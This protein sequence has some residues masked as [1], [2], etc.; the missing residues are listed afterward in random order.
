MNFFFLFY[1][2]NILIVL[3]ETTNKQNVS[4][5]N[6]F[7][8]FELVEMRDRLIDWLLLLLLSDPVRISNHQTNNC[9]E[10]K[11]IKFGIRKI[12]NTFQKLMFDCLLSLL[13]HDKWCRDVYEFIPIWLWKIH[14]SCGLSRSLVSFYQCVMYMC[15][16][17]LSVQMVGEK[18]A[19]FLFFLFISYNKK[20]IKLISFLRITF[21]DA[22][23]NF[24]NSHFSATIVNFWAFISSQNE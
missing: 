21:L 5:I 13:Y 1:Q 7:V 12:M 18:P 3:L 23:R 17:C 14:N 16:F 19:R 4:E 10:R 22:I 11:Y 8:H 2:E 9:S 24:M 20:K 6:V 15:Y